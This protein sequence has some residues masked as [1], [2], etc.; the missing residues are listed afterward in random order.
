MTALCTQRVCGS[1]DRGIRRAPSF[2]RHSETE[3]FPEPFSLK[4]ELKDAETLSDNQKKH[5]QKVQYF[6]Q[7]LSNDVVT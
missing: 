6:Q 3:P 5:L 1:E 7:L 4:S 2:I